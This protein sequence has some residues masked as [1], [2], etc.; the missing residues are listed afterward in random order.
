MLLYEGY[1]LF[2]GVLIPTRITTHV[3]G[4]DQVITLRNITLNGAVDSDFVP[5]PEIRRLLGS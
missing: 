2:E 3:E 1:G 5:P 4:V